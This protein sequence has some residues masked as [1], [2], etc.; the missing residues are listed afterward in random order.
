MCLMECSLLDDAHSSWSPRAHDGTLH[1]ML[2]NECTHA[3]CLTGCCGEENP[4]LY[5]AVGLVTYRPFGYLS[6]EPVLL[7]P[8][9]TATAAAG[10][11]YE[12]VHDSG[13]SCCEVRAWRSFQ[14]ACLSPELNMQNGKAK[15]RVHLDRCQEAATNAAAA[16]TTQKILMQQWQRLSNC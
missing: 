5:P 1:R 3:H 11:A 9:S 2:L 16:V 12:Y 14:S 7:D 13:E 4:L 10:G 15:Q 6:L 8:A